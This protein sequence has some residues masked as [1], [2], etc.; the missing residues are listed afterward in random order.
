MKN[1]LLSLFLAISFVLPFAHPA[2]A[3]GPLIDSSVLSDTDCVG[4]ACQY[5]LNTFM[6]LGI[7]VA[8][9]ILGIVGAVALVVFVYGGIR[10]MA[11]GGNAEAVST[12]KKSIVGAVI[13]LLLVF[14]SY[15]LISFTVNTVLKAD[16][17]YQFNGN[18]NAEVP[19]VVSAHPKCDAGDG[20][21][22]TVCTSNVDIS[23]GTLDCNKGAGEVCCKASPKEVNECANNGLERCVERQ[24]CALGCGKTKNCSNSTLLLDPVCC[25]TGS[26]CF[27]Q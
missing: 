11:S 16:G 4:P 6:K 20:T 21:C 5:S 26:G 12:G 3:L 17:N 1:I 2:Q 24:Q 14:G 25:S 8:N 15:S 18:I 7:N 27:N 23:L 9:I 22:K 19:V 10:M 13:G